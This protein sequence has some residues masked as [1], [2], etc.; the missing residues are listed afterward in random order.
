MGRPRHDPKKA[1]R[2]HGLR[3]RLDPWPA[4]ANAA[5][6]ARGQVGREGPAAGRRRRSLGRSPS[7]AETRRI[8]SASRATRVTC[9]RSFA[10]THHAARR[11][12]LTARPCA[13][14]SR[15]ASCESFPQRPL[16]SQ[17]SPVLAAAPTPRRGPMEPKAG[18]ARESF[19]FGWRLGTLPNSIRYP[20]RTY[21]VSG[22]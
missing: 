9:D 11:C 1:S 7:D 15:C 16:L 5:Q 19:T 22:Y 21:F 4:R 10:S 6:R 18:K 2:S 13:S 8:H 17:R 12:R 14:S 3:F 20:E